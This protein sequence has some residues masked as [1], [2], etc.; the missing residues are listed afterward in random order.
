MRVLVTGATGFVGRHLVAQLATLDHEVI[1]SSRA[2]HGPLGAARHL[3]HDV[4]RPTAFPETGHLDAIVHLAG[5]SSVQDAIDDPIGVAQTNAQGTLH[6][7]LRAREHGARFILASSQLTYERGPQPRTEKSPQLPLDLY[8]YTKLVAERYTAM[9]GRLFGTT[10]AIL[11]FF[12]VYGPGQ[13]VTHGTSGVVSIFAQHA[14]ADQPIRVL[15]HERRDFV[16]VSDV[17]EAIIAALTAA[18]CPPTAYNIGTGVGT[19]ID[20]L[21][22]QICA[23]AGSSSPILKGDSDQQPGDLVADVTRARREFG[24]APRVTLNEGLQAYVDWLR[25]I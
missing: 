24:Y 22:R 2:T 11:R 25:S 12:S 6:M 7:L 15:T 16:A 1:S 13:V 4:A 21:A 19:S 14:L 18:H 8:G 10:G 23:I 20:D 9:A 3:S 17:V 5:R